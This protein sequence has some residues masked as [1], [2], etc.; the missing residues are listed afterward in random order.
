MTENQV[1]YIRYH[2]GQ[3]TSD[4]LQ[5]VVDQT[6]TELADQGSTV[7]SEVASAGL[8]TDQIADAQISVAEEGQ[9]VEPVTTTIVI[10]IAVKAGS[11]IAIKLWDKVIWPRI[12]RRLGVDAL[13]S[14]QEDEQQ[15][16]E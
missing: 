1:T 13:G 3:A 8:S 2:Y 10:G 6:L 15:D 12:E 9:G 16:G 11:H 5:A 4:Q 7:A 14:R